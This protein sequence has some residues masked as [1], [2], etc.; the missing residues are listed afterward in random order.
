MEVVVVIGGVGGDGG[1]DVGDGGGDDG[2]DDK[3]FGR[4]Q[5]RRW[6]EMMTIWVLI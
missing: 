5:K 4:V 2:G 1:G 3:H 6:T